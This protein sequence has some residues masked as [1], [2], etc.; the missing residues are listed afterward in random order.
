MTQGDKEFE[1]VT[2]ICVPM[3]MRL[4]RFMFQKNTLVAQTPEEHE[5]ILEL[6]AGLSKPVRRQIRTVSLE[7]AQA[8][9][10][11]R[12]AQAGRG[13]TTS[14]THQMERIS[15]SAAAIAAELQRNQGPQAGMLSPEE[16]ANDP[17]MGMQTERMA[18]AQDFTKVF[19]GN[20]PLAPGANPE[21]AP[22]AKSGSFPGKK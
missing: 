17:S 21:A 18:D 22:A 15:L 9:A 8:I 2:F 11:E 5:E 1:P 14:A 12:V 3:R 13:Q 7:A 20:N 16:A 6:L 19:A 10:K 4:G